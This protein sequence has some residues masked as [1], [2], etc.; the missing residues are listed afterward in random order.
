M[1]EGFFLESRVHA[2]EI[3]NIEAS[4]GSEG[5]EILTNP[6]QDSTGNR[7]LPENADIDIRSAACGPA[8]FRAEEKE[9]ISGKIQMSRQNPPDFRMKP[10]NGGG[11]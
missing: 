7:F 2:A 1:F 5:V 8:A 9:M 10:A 11:G 3:H 4:K 6:L